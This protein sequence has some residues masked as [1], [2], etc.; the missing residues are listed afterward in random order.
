MGTID[1]MRSILTQPALDALCEKFHIPWTVHPELPEMDLF[2]FIRH[3]DPT[4]VRIGEREVREREVPLLELTRGRVVPLPCVNDQGGANVQGVGRDVVNEESGDAALADQIEES[5]RA[6]QDEG[7]N[8]VVD[9]E[10]EATVVDKP[11]RIRKKRKAADR[12]QVGGK[13][14]AAIQELFDRSTLAVEVEVTAATTFPFVTSSVTPTP[15]RKGGGHTDSVSGA[16][17][18]TRHPAERFVISSDSPHDSSANAADDEV[19]S[20]VTPPKSGSSGM[21]TMGCYVKVQQ[22]RYRKRP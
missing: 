4:K 22:S 3:T 11:K 5:D 7:V 15:E 21:V 9:E 16:N 10:I 13:S 14:L 20:I 17:L 18:R 6:A 8:V 1:D 12:C 19:T 2:A